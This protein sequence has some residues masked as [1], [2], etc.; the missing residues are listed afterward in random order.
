LPISQFC[1]SQPLFA[2]LRALRSF[3]P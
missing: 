3:L 2:F 1:T